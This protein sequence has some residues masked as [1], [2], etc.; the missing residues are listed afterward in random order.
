MD[1]DLLGN[2]TTDVEKEVARL[3]GE[4]K[5]LATRPDAPPCVSRN[6]SKALSCIWQAATDLNLSFEQ[7]YDVGV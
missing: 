6:A 4:L 2:P 1:Q 7:L 3:Y 5:A